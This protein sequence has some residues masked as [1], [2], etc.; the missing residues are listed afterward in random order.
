MAIEICIDKLLKQRGHT[1][2]W[3]AK[4]SGVGHTSVWK[5]RHGKLKQL[6]LE[7]LEHICRTLE[8]EPGDLLVMTDIKRKAKGKSEGRE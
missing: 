8:C 1:A 4:E 2:Y 7:H 3:L 5:M 6:N